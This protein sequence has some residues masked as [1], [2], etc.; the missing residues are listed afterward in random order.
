M[1]VLTSGAEI[2]RG[3]PHAVSAPPG[4]T[5]SCRDRSGHRNFPGSCNYQIIA[6]NTH[7]RLIKTLFALAVVCSSNGADS[8][9]IV[10]LGT[11]SGWRVSLNDYGWVVFDNKVLTPGASGYSTTSILSSAG[12]SNNFSLY[13]I[14]NS[15]V[16]LGVDS[17]AGSATAFVWHGGTRTNL[18]QIARYDS[19]TY[20]TA[21]GINDSGQIAGNTGDGAYIWTPNEAGGYITTPLGVDL[22]WT[23][24]S[25][26]AIGITN[27]VVGYF[28]YT[29]DGNSTQR[30]FYWDG[31][32]VAMLPVT[33]P[34]SPN[35]VARAINERGM[36]V[37][38]GYF[39][40]YDQ[41]AYLWTQTNGTW[42]HTDLKHPVLD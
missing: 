28:F 36:I 38:D 23:I 27:A 37:G 32:N 21:M 25:G 8:W 22:G 3:R 12:N 41:R 39:D 16:V 34:W 35:G 33:S 29:L 31:V 2:D 11:I 30:P 40:A 18:P 20:T 4:P 26:E 15:N 5:A 10:D 6:M 13:D 9:S 1:E 42:E 19:Y 24:G 17:S 14:N 7:A